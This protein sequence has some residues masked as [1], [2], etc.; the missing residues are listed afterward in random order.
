MR[1][2]KHP[3]ILKRD[4]IYYFKYCNENR[5]GCGKSFKPT[6]GGDV[7]KDCLKKMAVGRRKKR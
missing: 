2:T 7:C 4:K 6:S 3:G 1:K 5:G